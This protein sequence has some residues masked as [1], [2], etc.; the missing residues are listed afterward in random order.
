MGRGGEDQNETQA[1]RDAAAVGAGVVDT[2]ALSLDLDV[3]GGASSVGA[4]LCGGERLQR[5]R[6]FPR[7]KSSSAEGS[8]LE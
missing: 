3:R 8:L 7:P 2:W 6:R 1:V 4:D 5:W